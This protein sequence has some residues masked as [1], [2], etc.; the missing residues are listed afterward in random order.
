MK[1]LEQQIAL[2]A[3]SALDART[4]RTDLF[5]VSVQVAGHAPRRKVTVTLDGEEAGADIESCTAVSRT[6]ADRLEEEDAID[7]AY[8]LEVTSA[9]L[10]SPIA[11][12][13]QYR[14]HVGQRFRVRL[15]DGRQLEG[16]LQAANDQHITLLAGEGAEALDYPQI[17]SA[18]LIL[19][20]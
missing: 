11:Q 8:N 16:E 12:P 19:T 6:L 7:G 20:F 9:G 13:R 18:K 15:L 17:D 2:W 5:V 14:R 1:N 4:D 3:Q 10:T